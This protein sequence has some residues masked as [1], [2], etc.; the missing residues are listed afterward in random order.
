MGKTPGGIITRKVSGRQNTRNVNGPP[1]KKRTVSRQLHAVWTW[2]G[3]TEKGSPDL[4][5]GG[6]KGGRGKVGRLGTQGLG[7][8]QEGEGDTSAVSAGETQRG[9]DRCR[10]S[11][12]A[13]LG[14]TL[15]FHVRFL[16]GQDAEPLAQPL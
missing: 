8:T 10:S 16:A 9:P 13:G 4:A 5:W 1:R 2:W 15:P 7:K 6:L 11:K 3:R 14:T 12:G